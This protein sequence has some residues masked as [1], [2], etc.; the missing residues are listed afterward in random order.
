M[1]INLFVRKPATGSYPEPVESSPLLHILSKIHFDI[2]LY[3]YLGLLLR[4]SY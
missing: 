1:F 3:L 2:I 4:S